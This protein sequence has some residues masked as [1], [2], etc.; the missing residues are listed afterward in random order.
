MTPTREAIGRISSDLREHIGCAC[1]VSWVRPDRMHLTLHFYG[2]ADETMERRILAALAEPVPEA[3]F[4]LS[5]EGL[6]FFP[7]RGS[8]RV[9]WLGIRDGLAEL[10][11]LQQILGRCRRARRE[12]RRPTSGQTSLS[13]PI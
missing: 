9:L 7:P 2:Q 13:R 3:P 12:S 1:E 11:R 10:R 8:P 6:G 4:S 5:F